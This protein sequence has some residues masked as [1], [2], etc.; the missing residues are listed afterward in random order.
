MGGS[1]NRRPI[2]WVAVP[3]GLLLATVLATVA[4][5]LAS[6]VRSGVARADEDEKE[7]PDD[8]CMV[9]HADAKEVGRYVVDL[10]A[11]RAGVHGRK[12]CTECHF[13]Y[14]TTPHGKDRKTVGCAEC[15]EDAAKDVLASA[16]KKAGELPPEHG[17]APGRARRDPSCVA[18]HGGAHEI[19]KA[20]DPKSRLHPLNVTV[21][22]GSC[23]FAPEARGDVEIEK[24]LLEKYVDDTHVRGLL[25]SG[26][27]VAATCVSCHGGHKVVPASNPAS[28]V[29]HAN[30]TA[31]CGSCHLG[32]QQQFD[33]GVHGKALREGKGLDGKG[34]RAPTCV[35]CHKPHAIKDPSH[36][37]NFK[38]SVV[39]TCGE[40]H[41]DR[42]GTYRNT[43]HGR[44][45]DLGFAGVAS[46]ADCHGAHGILPSSDPASKVH[47][48][49]PRTKTCATCHEGATDAFA[50]YPVHADPHD[51]VAWPQLYWPE[52]AMRWLIYL[53]MGVMGV[54]TLLWLQRGLRERKA[55][56]AACASRSGRWYRRWPPV[57]RTLHLTLVVSFLLLAV[58]GI[59]IRFHGESWAG[60][61]TSALG[62]PTVMRFL[63]RVGAVLTAVYFGGY[64]FHLVLRIARREQGLFTGPDTMLPRWKDVLD[65]RDHVRWFL[66]GGERPKFE[67]WTYWE[68]FDYWAVFWG[69]A[70]IGISGLI[71]WFPIAA[72]S[73]LPAW[74][75]N[76]AHAIHSHEALLAVSFIFTFHFFHSNLRPGKFPLDPMFLTGVVSE[77]ELKFEHRA[78]WERMAADGRL[79]REALPPPDPALVRR[80]YAIGGV[81]LSVGL[82]LLVLLVVAWLR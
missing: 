58:T 59:P 51:K 81:L 4:S 31:T 82:G 52:F 57:Y 44:V 20:S 38:M 41:A 30:V 7:S 35:S 54:H 70:V 6:G 2:R 29:H 60:W 74:S 24:V 13:D 46:C 75:I 42:M 19:R 50:A 10:A 62:G 71:M 56:H 79:E 34:P 67:R 27:V 39:E 49:G 5:L 65:V 17:P 3:A 69:V 12:E 21:T 33:A 55:I 47:H 72:T 45:S 43:Y 76:L 14:D 40:C 22:C 73:V 32:I 53:T 36:H 16:H 9:C 26:L 23:H 48:P 77:E 28:P 18:C 37:G 8:A 61:L 25:R 64:L 80:A 63:H 11:H 68:K 78:E 1:T 15:H 66:R